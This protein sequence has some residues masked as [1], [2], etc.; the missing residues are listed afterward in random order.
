MDVELDP[1]Q[2]A[3]VEHEAG[4]LLVEGGFGSGKSVALRARAE[5]LR[6]EG[7]R[8]LLL[9]HRELVAVAVAI[10]RR[11]GRNVEL[12]HPTGLRYFA[13]RAVGSPQVDAGEAVAAI[14]GFQASFL[15]DE[16]LRVHADAAG[17]LD[18][19]EE[20]IATTARHGAAMAAGGLV[21]PGGALVEASL[22]LRDVDVLA[23]E[24]ARFD[25]LL[26]DDFQLASFATN[27]LVSQLAGPGGAVIVAGNADAAVSTMPLASAT[28][29]E[30][31]P[32][33]F[34]AGQ[35]TLT[36]SY[37]SPGPPELRLLEGDRSAAEDAWMIRGGVRRA[38]VLLIGR[39]EVEA[40]VGTEAG[41]VL[42]HG[43][44]DGRWPAPQPALRW[45]DTELF[46]GPDVPD[47]AERARRWR[48]FE[49]RRFLVATTRATE[50]TVVLAHPPV[51][52]LIAELLR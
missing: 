7:K 10:L 15:G 38:D 39:D 8:P 41:V 25:E 17:C 51:T 13:E 6:A 49:R 47:E 40:A 31:F 48:A 20:L 23:A 4:P 19:A 1:A 21:D 9:H 27:R 18:V 12:V 2:Q 44:T 22:L 37:R 32:R 14:V 35:V 3:V 34:G 46:H 29:L 28:H 45:F 24:R 30:R 50:R 33:R 5:R 52:P 43:A 42:V 16:E 11:H 36:A 26:V